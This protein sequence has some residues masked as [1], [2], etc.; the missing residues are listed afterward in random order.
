MGKKKELSQ[1]DRGRILAYHD[2]GLSERQ[3]AQKIPCSKGTVGYVLKKKATFGTTENR[4]RS[5][6]P[7]ATTSAQ[8]KYIR[9][10]TLMDRFRPAHD[11]ARNVI[12][13]KSKRQVTER[14]VRNRLCE[15][16]LPSRVARNKPKLTK[17]QRQ[18][19]LKWARKYQSW[20]AED[21]EKILW[22]D[23]SPFTL[24]VKGGK[25]MVRR[26]E[27]E[28]YVPCCMQPT[29]KFGG[30]SINVWG[31]FSKQGV[32]DIYRIQGIMTGAMYREILKNHMAPTLRALGATFKFQHDN[33]PKHTSKVVK[34]YL[35]NAKFMV[36]DWPSQS[37]DLNPIENLWG[38]IKQKL[39]KRTIR[40]S[41]LDEVYSIVKEEWAALGKDYL[42][43]LIH[44]MPRR[45]EA[46]IKAKGG[47]IDY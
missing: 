4:P 25:V 12:N 8:D 3:I 11:I 33:D 29:V 28:A 1:E 30:G 27:R 18:N 13:H 22:S 44:S 17:K 21:W 14:T 31:C 9:V 36:L 34:K 16:G 7:R 32:G 46:V 23:E 10:A 24:F 39:R 45:I 5:G 41:S 43:S 2:S 47:S 26:R 6:R 38:H 42:V 20:K 40:P 37:P 15:A 35:F 19:R